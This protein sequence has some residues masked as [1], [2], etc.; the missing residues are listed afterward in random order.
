[1]SGQQPGA[2]ANKVPAPEVP[3]PEVP[4]APEHQSLNMC[5]PQGLVLNPF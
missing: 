5:I 4:A 2:T 3:A 1:M